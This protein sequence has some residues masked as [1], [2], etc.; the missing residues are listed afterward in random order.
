MPSVKV[1]N[2]VFSILY[3]PFKLINP[4]SLDV[5]H[6]DL[7]MFIKN[8]EKNQKRINEYPLIDNNKEISLFNIF[9]K[10][11]LIFISP[12]P[13]IVCTFSPIMINLLPKH[14][15]LSYLLKK[16]LQMNNSIKL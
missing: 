9:L 2:F 10:E 12:I 4:T 6:N 7:T 5:I 3:S 11:K 15:N 13:I 8:H 14:S 16:Y 1:L